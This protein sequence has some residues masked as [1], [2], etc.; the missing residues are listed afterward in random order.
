MP[1]YDYSC[2]NCKHE[3]EVFQ[4]M[5]ESPLTTCPACQQDSFK[6]KPG[7]GAGLHFTGSGFYITDYSSSAKP[8]KSSCCP[9]GK[10][11]S[12]SSSQ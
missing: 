2:S 9:C 1:H 3:Q 5:T 10:E 8:Q 6:R 11:S 7:G 4:K 12:C